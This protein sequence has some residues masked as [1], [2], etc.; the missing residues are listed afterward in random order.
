MVRA[1]MQPDQSEDRET[2]MCVRDETV[3]TPRR[4]C[5]FGL[6]GMADAS[7]SD[8]CGPPDTVLALVGQCTILSKADCNSKQLEGI[9]HP[10]LE[11]CSQVGAC[12]LACFICVPPPCL[13]LSAKLDTSC[14][15]LSGGLPGGSL[16]PLRFPG[17]QGGPVVGA[18]ARRGLALIN[19]VGCLHAGTALSWPSGCTR[20]CC[21]AS[22]CFF[23]ST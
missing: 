23:S 22:L 14:H 6:A 5:C 2:C 18:A 15:A 13:A 21:T 10:D 20:A 11:L 8:G 17:R 1:C 16:R 19:S 12:M 4:P 7:R 9:W 3:Q